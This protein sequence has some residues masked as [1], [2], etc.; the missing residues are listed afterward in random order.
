MGYNFNLWGWVCVKKGQSKWLH[1]C[2]YTPRLGV[3]LCIVVWYLADTA[4][5]LRMVV[6]GYSYVDQVKEVVM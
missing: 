2:R 1:L 4:W 3:A 6:I 5:L